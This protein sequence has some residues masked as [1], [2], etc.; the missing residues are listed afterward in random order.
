MER[1]TSLFETIDALMKSCDIDYE[2]LVG[3]KHD[4][5]LFTD[6]TNQR[7][8]NSF[9]FNYMK[10]QD[11]IGAKLFRGILFELREIDDESVS[12]KDM[13][14]RLEKLQL[15]QSASQWDTLREI[16]NAIAHEYPLDTQERLENFTMAIHG[17]RLLKQMYV[18]LKGEVGK[19]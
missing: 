4:E 9:L 17:Y 13:L 8:V 6:Y 14:N 10:I 15:I 18:T 3:M 16:R 7:I 12:M 19:V 11:K 5:S 2:L 1:L